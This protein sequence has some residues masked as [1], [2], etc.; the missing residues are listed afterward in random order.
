ME[1]KQSACI[2]SDPIIRF[3]PELLQKQAAVPPAGFAGVWNNS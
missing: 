3:S 2:I 1:A